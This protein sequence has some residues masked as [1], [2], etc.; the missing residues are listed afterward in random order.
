MRAAY[1]WSVEV[2]VYVDRDRLRRGIGIGLYTALLGC[3]R[4]QGFRTA[5]GVITVPNP[6]S[7]GLHERLGFAR[8][9]VIPGLG[10]KHG[11]WRDVGWWHLALA[12]RA[13]APP[14]PV[15]LSAAI[16]DPR[17]QQALTAGAALVRA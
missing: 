5:V 7:V 17:W 3:L 8:A 15:A 4:V 1:G 12:E 13:A 6:E 11:Q 9:G 10:W 14:P 16:G 2:T